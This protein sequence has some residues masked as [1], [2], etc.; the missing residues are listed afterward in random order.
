[1]DDQLNDVREGDELDWA[2][3][4]RHLRSVLDLPGAPMQVRQFTGGAANL[5]YLASFGDRRIVVRRPPRGTIAPGA[6]DMAR[7]HRVLS[8]LPDAYPRAPRALHF[9]DDSSII[10]APF[11][12]VE[13]RDGVVLRDELPESMAY[14]HEVRMRV[15]VALINAVADLHAV[16][17][18]A[19]GLEGLGRPDGYANRQVEG[20]HD[21]WRRV[22]PDDD[23]GSMDEVARRLAATMPVPQ[24]VAVV[25]NDLKLDNCQ[26]QTD[27]PDLVTSVF[28]WDMATLGDPLFDLGLVL[29]SMAGNP[30]WAIET[31]DAAQRYAVRSGLD[32]SHLDW[33]LAFATWRTAVVIQQLYRRYLAGDAADDRLAALGDAIDSCVQRALDLTK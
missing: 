14:Q 17:P 22:A 8:R 29:N 20:W 21:R 13:Y 19:V 26:F 24:R 2:T 3:L 25:H 12:V 31:R 16:A 1:M 5:T 11:V 4:E 9:T 33:Y 27:D 28:D 7:E 6:H 30:L 10:G 18:A 23:T 32:V 15:D